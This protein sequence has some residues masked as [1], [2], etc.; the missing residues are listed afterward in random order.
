MQWHASYLFF[1]CQQTFCCLCFKNGSPAYIMSALLWSCISNWYIQSLIT[2]RCAVM[3][4][5][6][7]K[8]H[9][10]LDLHHKNKQV[11]RFPPIGVWTNI[12]SI[13]HAAPSSGTQ[14]PRIN[15]DW[16]DKQ[17]LRELLAEWIKMSLKCPAVS[18][19]FECAEFDYSVGCQHKKTIELSY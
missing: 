7:W 12:S 2:S 13:Q 15:S 18:L 10:S 4:S 6:Y 5:R 11:Q 9:G 1:C 19:S 3:V 14:N 17:Q 8:I 16:S